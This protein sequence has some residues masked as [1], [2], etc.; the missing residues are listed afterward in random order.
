MKLTKIQKKWVEDW[1]GDDSHLD[2][3][4]D[5]LIKL[6]VIKLGTHSLVRNGM[7]AKIRAWYH[8]EL[9]RKQRHLSRQENKTYDNRPPK[10]IKPTRTRF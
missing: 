3:L 8:H 9:D 1:G 6:R 5:F 4:L 10:S 2:Y 7:Y